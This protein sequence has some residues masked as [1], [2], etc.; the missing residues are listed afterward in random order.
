MSHTNPRLLQ[1]FTTHGP[2]SL[3]PWPIR[4]FQGKQN[5]FTHQNVIGLQIDY[6]ILRLLHSPMVSS[7]L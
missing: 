7:S 6:L 2:P 1:Q 4:Y 3:P 5:Y